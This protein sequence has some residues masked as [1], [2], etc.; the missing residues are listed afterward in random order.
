MSVTRSSM[1]VEEIVTEAYLLGS[2]A[3]LAFGPPS[4][5]KVGAEL[6]IAG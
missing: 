2:Q 4:C 6:G 5:I 1:G 3:R